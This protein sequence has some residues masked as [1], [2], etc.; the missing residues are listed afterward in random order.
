VS[1][2]QTQAAAALGLSMNEFWSLTGNPQFPAP[3]STD[4]L[5]L[6]VLWANADI[7]N[8]VTLMAQASANGWTWDSND[9][10][11]ADWA[12]LASSSPGPYAFAVTRQGGGAPGLFD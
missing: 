6:N 2:T 9:L 8:F 11:G 5:G 7:T 3:I 10:A 4:D 1:M 12:T